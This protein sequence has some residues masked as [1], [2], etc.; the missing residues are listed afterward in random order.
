LDKNTPSY[1]LNV[2]VRETGI[3]P[4]TLRAWERRYGL[5]KPQRT[6][7]GHRLYSSRDIEMIRWMMARQD[8]GMRISQVVRMWKDLA[9]DGADPLSPAP[10]S[11][12]DPSN[13][14]DY[15]SDKSLAQLRQA[16]VEN[17]L[18]FN[19]GTADQIFSQALARYPVQV[20]CVEVLQKGL[21]TIGERW[22]QSGITIQ[23][24][25][26][27]SA[28]AVKRLNA[29]I[30]AAPAPSRT[31]RIVVGC[32]PGEEHLFSPLLASLLL[33]YHGY[34][35]TYLGANVPLENLQETISQIK[36][37]LVVFTAMQLDTAT[38]LINTSRVLEK[39]GVPQ[40]FGGR[41]FSVQPKLQG[42]IPGIF[43][44]E[45]LS[46]VPEFVSRA[47]TGE[48][49]P[50]PPFE[51]SDEYRSTL[52]AFD[53]IHLAVGHK[54]FQHYANTEF[55]VRFL[56]LIN[57]HFTQFLF[58]ALEL[59]NLDFLSPELDWSESLVANNRIPPQ[60]VSDYL[61]AYK[62]YLNEVGG[63]SL[64]LITDWLDDRLS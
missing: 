6:E 38:S 34:D 32:P 15:S 40:A 46:Q 14:V 41:I 44:G 4:D 19:E 29:L 26:F 59:G 60:V 17:C 24:E 13:T 28:I 55:P 36:P 10:I 5:P 47:L 18:V 25:H 42:L 1:N 31:E 64:S 22:Y 20:A 51:L 53:R 2:V 48:I 7:G 54:L 35:V 8:E 23:Q 45:Q 30:A 49:A 57:Q 62:T 21:N 33:R 58:A 27:A 43:L 37:D 50:N 39:Q 61:Q 9:A 52:E 16:W 56:E 12:P 3:K 63:D 11:L